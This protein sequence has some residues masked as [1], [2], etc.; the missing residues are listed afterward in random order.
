MLGLY[1]HKTPELSWVS[2]P[3]MSMLLFFL[4]DVGRLLQRNSLELVICQVP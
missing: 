1:A 2:R 4:E 3:N